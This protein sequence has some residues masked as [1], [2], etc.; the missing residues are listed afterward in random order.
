MTNMPFDQKLAFDTELSIAASTFTGLSQ[1]IGTLNNEPVVIFFKN[2]TSVSVF[3]ADN[4]DS[5]KGMTMAIGEEI[6][7]DC[8]ANSAKAVNM[9]F[10]IGT[11][12]FITGAVG[13]G[14]FKI[15]IIYAY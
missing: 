1:L 12:F 6:V 15:S 10:P 11:S 7:L 4:P 13:T 5:T 3:L 8:R 14:N 9:G 2:Q